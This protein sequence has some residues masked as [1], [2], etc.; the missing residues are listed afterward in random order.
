MKNESITRSGESIVDKVLD[1]AKL[2]SYA[3]GDGIE[4]LGDKIEHLGE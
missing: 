2:G 3:A 4:K 1:K